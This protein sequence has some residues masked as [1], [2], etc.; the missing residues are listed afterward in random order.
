MKTEIGNIQTKLL[1]S[2]S[3]YVDEDWG[4]LDYYAPNF[5]VQWPCTLIDVTDINF[6]NIGKDRKA[7]PVNRQQAQGIVTL[8]IANLK[9]TN[10]SGQAPQLQKDNVWSIWDLIEE[11]HK[12]MQGFRISE[13]GGDLI[14][15]SLQRIKRDDGV[16]QYDITYSF[17]LNNV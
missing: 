4:Q 10:S 5:P 3:K 15:R 7:T 11:T 12:L 9:L 6:D 17:S 8:T 14:R 16:Q 13:N 1:K 2:S